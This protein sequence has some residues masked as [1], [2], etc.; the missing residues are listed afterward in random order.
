M[1]KIPLKAGHHR[2]ASK[3]PFWRRPDDGLTLNSG[4]VAMLFRG[5]VPVLLRKSIVV[6]FEGAGLDPLLPPP[7]D[8]PMPVKKFQPC[9]DVSWVESVLNRV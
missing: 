7:L 1:I 9:Q 6:I 4:L 8:P 2:P 5:S 3:M